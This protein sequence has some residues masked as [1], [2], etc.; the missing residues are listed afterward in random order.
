MSLILN[1]PSYPCRP[2]RSIAALARVLELTEDA[3]L[4]EAAKANGNYRKV[5]PKEGSKRETFD[6]RGL[7]KIIH[8]RIKNTIFSK[9]EFPDY[10]H[11]SLK[12]CDYVSNAKLHTNKQLLMCEDVKSF[13]PSVTDSK[14]EDV[15]CGFFGFSIE[16]SKLLMQLTTK[17]NKLPQ[18]SI[19]SSYLANLVLWRDEPLLEAKLAAKGITYSRYVDDMMMSSKAYLTKEVQRWVIAQVYGMLRRNGLHAGRAKH[20]IFSATEPM[21]AT[22]LT[23]N[24]KPSLSPEKRAQVRAQVLQLEQSLSSGHCED[25]IRALANKAAQ[26]VGQLG[27]FHKTQAGQLKA[28]VKAV[29]DAL[30]PESRTSITTSRESQPSVTLRPIQDGRTS[31][32]IT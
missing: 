23:V 30:P 15:W 18:G 17:D 3:L 27:R 21:I 28:R 20:E 26:R 8:R 32:L 1:K 31:A 29:R 24:A 13:F 10:L 16:V 22:K 2:I 11:G 12:G 7:L 6:A 25:E 5:P 14:V 19:T 4:A 9:V